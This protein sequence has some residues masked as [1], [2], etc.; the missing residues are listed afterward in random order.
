MSESGGRKDVNDAD[1]KK[2]QELRGWD[3]V[4]NR[5][6]NDRDLGGGEDS[7]D[8]F[9]FSNELASCLSTGDSA[10]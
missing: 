2:T 8:G 3:S 6:V 7:A 1:G 9:I 5:M 10:P 4:S